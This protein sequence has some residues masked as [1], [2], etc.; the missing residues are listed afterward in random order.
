MPK[1]V[2]FV[3]DEGVK[4]VDKSYSKEKPNIVQKQAK[5]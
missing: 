1:C 2:S 5:T 4:I 3:L